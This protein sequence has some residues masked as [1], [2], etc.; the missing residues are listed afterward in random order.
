MEP[1]QTAMML[2][3]LE[4]HNDLPLHSFHITRIQNLP[5][6][7][8]QDIVHLILKKCFAKSCNLV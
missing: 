6:D 1:F 7:V 5:N 8:I 2:H 4:L 3:S